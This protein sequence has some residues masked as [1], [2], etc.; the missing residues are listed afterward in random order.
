M[1]ASCSFVMKHVS[2]CALS[3]SMNRVSTRFRMTRELR[4]LA[5]RILAFLL[6]VLHVANVQ[7]GGEHA[8]HVLH[9]VVLP[10]ECLHRAEHLRASKRR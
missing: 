2:A 1:A 8:P 6:F 4:A 9:L 3:P 5:Y 10:A 7:H